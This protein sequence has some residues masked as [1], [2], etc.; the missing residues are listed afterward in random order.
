MALPVDT[1]LVPQHTMTTDARQH[2]E[3]LLQ[4]L[5]LAQDIALSNMKEAQAKSKEHHDLKAKEPDFTL[6]D[7][8][9]MRVSKVPTG[10]SPKLF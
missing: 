7:R 6:H 2:F 1:A 5:K 9:L 4:R 8:V 10:L 3:E